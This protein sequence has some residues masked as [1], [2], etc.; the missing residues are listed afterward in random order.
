MAFGGSAIKSSID[1]PSMS[2]PVILPPNSFVLPSGKCISIEGL[3]TIM[4]TEKLEK[5]I[6]GLLPCSSSSPAQRFVF[7]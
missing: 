4:E 5:Y 3:P 1:N 2:S 6:F 7:T